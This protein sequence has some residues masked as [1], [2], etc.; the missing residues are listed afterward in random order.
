[1]TER[2][3]DGPPLELRTYATFDWAIDYS[4]SQPVIAAEIER[5]SSILIAYAESDESRYLMGFDFE[6][7]E[8]MGR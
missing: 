2:N 3:K 8:G 4:T 7:P 6:V 5:I 1:M